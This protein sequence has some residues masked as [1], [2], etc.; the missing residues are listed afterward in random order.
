MLFN[1]FNFFIFLTIVIFLYVIIQFKYRW[2]ILLLSSLFFYAYWRIEYTILILISASVDFFAARGIYSA[3]NIL[4][5][6]IWLSISLFTNLGLLVLFKYSSFILYFF[7]LKLSTFISNGYI[8][9]DIIIPI[10][11]SFY[12]FQTLSYTID[13]YRNKFIPVNHYTKF[14]LFVSFFPQLIAGPIERAKGLLVQFFQFRQITHIDVYK[15]IKLILWGLFKKLIIADKV[16]LFIDP[17]Y[18]D[19]IKYNG[20]FLMIATYLFAFQILCDFSGYCDIAIGTAKLF[21]YE[22]S[23]N[24]NYPYLSRSIHDFWKRWHITLSNW[25][26]DYLYIPLGGK[27]VSILRWY[28][29]IFFVFLV[30]GLWHGANLKF[31]LWG[32]IH[33][34]LYLIENILMK[35]ENKLKSLNTIY[36]LKTPIN[37]CK[38]II[39]FHLICFAWIFFRADSISTGN[40]IFINILSSIPTIINSIS[41][42]SIEMFRSTANLSYH[43]FYIYAIF[44]II[45]LFLYYFRIIEKFLHRDPIDKF[46]FSDIFIF[47]F[48]IISII[49]FSNNM[50]REFIYF[51]F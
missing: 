51:Q 4:I 21:G 12:T 11:I 36:T 16:A 22:L 18:A 32:A 24:F 50:N 41:N 2:I 3:K 10:G 33:G 49:I 35:I 20:L 15:G 1:S 26:K 42:V 48:L 46:H 38:S 31:L 28:F 14:I 5:K 8:K 34:L 7:N 43:E 47:N 37:I 17:I 40:Y 45:F 30:S 19:P 6:K 9:P 39:T 44:F 27:R 29:N 13:V 23:L 25:F